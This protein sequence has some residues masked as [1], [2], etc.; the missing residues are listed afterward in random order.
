MQREDYTY[1]GKNRNFF[2]A[3]IIAFNADAKRWLINK[4]M[5]SD[6]LFSLE[7]SVQMLYN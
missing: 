3:V 7:L 5:Q 6:Y 4:F 2:V 1:I